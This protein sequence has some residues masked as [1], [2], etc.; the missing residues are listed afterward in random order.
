MARAKNK[1]QLLEWGEKEFENLILVL[2]ELTQ[3]QLIDSTVFGNRTVKD[4]IAHLYAWHL[5]F[6]RWYKEGMAG[7]KPEKPAPDYSWKETPQLNEELFQKYK[8]VSWQEI[9]AKFKESHNEI[10]A[11]IERHGN[12]DLEEKKQYAWTGST[13]MASYLAAATTSHYRWATSLIRK[14]NLIPSTRRLKS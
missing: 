11:L 13:S 2:D 5:L 8:D 12:S 14:A 3:E 4:M 6:L 1:Q 10:M 7:R 9:S